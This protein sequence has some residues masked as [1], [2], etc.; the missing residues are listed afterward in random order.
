[1]TSAHMENKMWQHDSSAGAAG[2][3]AA[4]DVLRLECPTCGKLF[5]HQDQLVL[6]MHVHVFTGDRASAG[7]GGGVVGGRP[8]ASD[9]LGSHPSGLSNGELAMGL[10]GRS[11][12]IPASS[13]ASAVVPTSTAVSPSS[14]AAATTGRPFKCTVC[15]IAFR[16]MG[17]L[18]KHF[19]SKSHLRALEKAGLLKASLLSRIHSL[20]IRLQDIIDQETGF[21]VVDALNK[22]LCQADPAGELVTST[23]PTHAGGGP[24]PGS[25]GPSQVSPYHRPSGRGRGV[26][27]PRPSAWSPPPPPSAPP[28]V[29]RTS[30]AAVVGGGGPGPQWSAD[31]PPSRSR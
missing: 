11:A 20:N 26:K 1:M 18:G 13:V 30:A 17:H 21:I 3:S 27:R 10:L 2:N 16:V 9:L 6:H 29:P 14:S 5:A 31:G 7:A 4:D 19:R 25:L 8:D 23:A 22:L 24:L 28:R 15:S 12:G